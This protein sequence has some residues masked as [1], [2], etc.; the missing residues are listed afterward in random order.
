MPMKI[1]VCGMRDPSNIKSIDALGIDFMGFIFYKKSP[2]YTN[3]SSD[4]KS[5]IK[6]QKIGVFVNSSQEEILKKAAE[7]QLRYVQ[8]HGSESSD[9]CAQLNQ[10]G[11]AIIK[12]FQV[13]NFFDFELIKAYESVCSYFLFD[14]KG[15]H[16]GGNGIQFNWQIL[17]KYQLDIPYFLSGGIDL[18]SIEILKNMHLPGL[19]AIDINSKFEIDPGMKNIELVKLLT[20]KLSTLKYH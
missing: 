12:A 17:K 19:Y 7:H 5:P 3:Y 13:D 15:K 9:F 14:A 8:L 2:R 18:D 4:C 6:A 10:K 20:Q 16:Y 11:L 1:K